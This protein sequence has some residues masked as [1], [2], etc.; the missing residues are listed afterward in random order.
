MNPEK[1]VHGLLRVNLTSLPLVLLA[2][3]RLLSLHHGLLLD[4]VLL[5]RRGPNLVRL[6]LGLLPDELDHLGDLHGNLVG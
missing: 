3:L 1:N 5:L 6:L 4:G 2:N